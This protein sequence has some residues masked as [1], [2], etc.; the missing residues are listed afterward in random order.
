MTDMTN[1][2]DPTDPNRTPAGETTAP[3]RSRR[4]TLLISGGAV[5]AAAAL[6][7]GGIAVGSAVAD[8]MDENDTTSETTEQDD[9]DDG[10][11]DDSDATPTAGAASADELLDIIETASAEADGT[12]VEIEA[13]ADG[14]WN[15]EFTTD[16]GD[17]T[18]VRVAS[19]GNA[20]VVGTESADQNDEA[21]A[22]S[23]DAATL[24]AL[25]TAA[26]A[27]TDGTVIGVELDG[28]TA[29]AYDVTVLTADRDIVE[30]ALDSE[31][32]VLTSDADD[33]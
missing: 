9:T 22:G 15:V 14:S 31:F 23:L 24:E 4:R 30:I 2:T 3:K 13:E 33:D 20:S 16:S 6:I 32:S 18:E 25:V 11:A 17:E 28:D 5:L 26:L 19:D 10:A 8:E 12:P 29:S 1:P 7:G 27:D 21:P